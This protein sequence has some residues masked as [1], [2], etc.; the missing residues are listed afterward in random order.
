MR[1]AITLAGVT[2]MPIRI[3]GPGREP[4][5]IRPEDAIKAISL[6]KEGIKLFTAGPPIIHRGP[7]GEIHVD[8]PLMYN[9]YALDR[10]HYDPY[11]NTFSPK[12]R[13]VHAINVQISRDT[14]WQ[15]SKQYVKELYVIE[16][17]EYR[18]P[19]DVWVVP[20]AWRC[21]IV[22][23]IKVSYDGEELVPDYPLTEEITG[24]LM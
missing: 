14:V 23:H 8:V 4:R 19:E 20:L 21:F 16:A 22:A 24:R 7:A 13:P 12:G 9:G 18:E 3:R 17:V 15:L 2:I 11:T 1:T 5:R 6:V 10:I